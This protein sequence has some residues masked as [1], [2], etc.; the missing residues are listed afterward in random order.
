LLVTGSV[1]ASAASPVI[2]TQIRCRGCNR[3]LADLVNELEGG[4]VIL[5]LKCPRCGR[6]H[7]ELVRP[8][9]ASEPVKP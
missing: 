8:M 7:L 1:V 3:R 2:R 5:E 6:P 9:P 4:Q